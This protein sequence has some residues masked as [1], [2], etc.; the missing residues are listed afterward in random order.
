MRAMPCHAMPGHSPGPRV[1]VRKRWSANKRKGDAVAEREEK[2]QKVKAAMPHAQ[3]ELLAICGVKKNGKRVEWY[4]PIQQI[5][6]GSPSISSRCVCAEKKQKNQKKGWWGGMYARVTTELER[7]HPDPYHRG[8]RR[9]GGGKTEAFVG[10][11]ER[12]Q[13]SYPSG[14]VPRLWRLRMIRGI[15]K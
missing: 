4:L 5:K 13:L 7:N 6:R 9:W 12:V 3:I 11:I 1:R 2:N 14:S 10:G 8:C 15:W